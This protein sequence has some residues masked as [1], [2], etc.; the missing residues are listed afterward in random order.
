MADTITEDQVIQAARELGQD[1]FT[2]VELA[3]KLGVQRG[4][5][6]QAFKAARK[7]GRVEKTVEGGEGSGRPRF[8]LTGK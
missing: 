8:R 2:R 7:A 4:E 3:E 5:L 1:E 6:K